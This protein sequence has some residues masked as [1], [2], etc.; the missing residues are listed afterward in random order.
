MIKSFS[1]ENM[2]T[3]FRS[4]E[5]PLLYRFDSAKEELLS[6]MSDRL[7][8]TRVYIEKMRNILEASNPHLILEKGYSMVRDKETGKVTR[9][10]E[11]T[12]PGATI[13]IIP[14]KGKITATVIE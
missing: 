13:E 3:R 9:G 8:E 7:K 10:I 6:S 14:A 2:E 12:S 1:P 4:I 5:Q 11:D